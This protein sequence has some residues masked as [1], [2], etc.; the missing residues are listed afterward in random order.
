[1]NDPQLSTLSRRCCFA[2]A[3]ALFLVF[4]SIGAPL[5]SAQGGQADLG[6]ILW[7]AETD[8]EFKDLAD[9]GASV[10]DDV[11]DPMKVGLAPIKSIDLER[12]SDV[13]SRI[14]VAEQGRPN[15]SLELT[16]EPWDGKKHASLG[17]EPSDLHPIVELHNM[18]PNPSSGS[19]LTLTGSPGSFDVNGSTPDAKIQALADDLGL[20]LEEVNVGVESTGFPSLLGGQ[21]I[22]YEEAQGVC[23]A[24]ASFNLDCPSCTLVGFSGPSGDSPI[25]RWFVGGGLAVF[26]DRDRLVAVTVSYAFDVNESAILDPAAARGEAVQALRNR[27]YEVGNTPDA[28]NVTPSGI[29]APD[30]VEVREIRYGWTFDV[31]EVQGDYGQGSASGSFDEYA[32]VTQNAVTGAVLS[33]NVHPTDLTDPADPSPLEI[34]A[35]S[36]FAT[37]LAMGAA[38]FLGGQRRT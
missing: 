29:L 1:M 31:T 21:R 8:R 24:S 37:L 35:P 23:K 22:C 27:G 18:D 26:D 33:M 11:V 34:V 3:I 36:W 13:S 28:R 17:I 30:R 15:F 10:F 25:D 19:V 32:R 12:T 38:L 2:S 4:S 7:P 6:E 20:P 14:L 16:H 9:L 5:A